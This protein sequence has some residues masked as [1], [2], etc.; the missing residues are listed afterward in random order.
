MLHAPANAPTPDAAPV[1]SAD[2]LLSAWRAH[3]T[4]TGRWNPASDWAARSFLSRWS[5]PQDWADQPLTTRLALPPSTMSLL[6]FLMVRG[7]LRPGWDWLVAKK[8]SSFWREVDG[9]RLE[10]DMARFCDTAVAVG[11]TEIQAK[12]AAA[13]QSVGRLLIQTGRPLDQLCMDDLDELAAAC[14]AREAA[15]GRGWRHYRSA[16]VCAHTVLFHLD[17]VEVPAEP[18]QQPECFETRLA[19]CQLNLRPA[20][21][22]YLERK[23]G[24]CRPK[25]VSSLATR[26][27]HFGRFLAEVDPDLDSLAGLHRQRHIEPYLNSV[28]N[29]VSAKTGKPIT[30]ADQDR[31]IHAVGHMLAEITEWDGMTPRPA[32]S[33]SAPTIPASHDRCRAMCPSTPIAASPLHSRYPTTG[34][35]PTRCCSPGLLGFASASCSTSNSTACTRSTATAPDSRFRSAS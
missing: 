30:V 14:R 8:L 16:L 18:A 11:F 1:P 21:V 26:L 31:R 5:R 7:W 25:T 22:A 32:S 9:S 6:M 35:Q 2:G 15:T 28:A 13:S 10:A 27:A 20:F 29:A 12:R 17:I 33:S 3:Q 24:A 4:A 34:L 19:D 23:L